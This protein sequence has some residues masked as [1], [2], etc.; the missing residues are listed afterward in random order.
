M[1]KQIKYLLGVLILLLI[2]AYFLSLLSG[3]PQ[4]FKD[5]IIAFLEER[6]SGDISFSSVSLWPLNRL[7]LQSFSFTAQNGSRFIFEELNLDYNLNLSNL[8]KIIE[9]KLIEAEKA[10]IVITEDFSAEKNKNSSSALDLDSAADNQNGFD[11][12]NFKL[13]EFLEGINLNILDTKLKIQNS[14]YNL[15]FDNLNLGLVGRGREEY[16]LNL[17]TA[18]LVNNLSF[19]NL[20]L[21]N[22]E[23]KKIELQ[24]Q[25]QHN[26]AEIYFQT[27]AST[28]KPFL[29]LLPQQNYELQALNLDLNNV[30]GSFKTKGE[31]EIEGSEITNYKAEVNFE[32]LDLKAGYQKQNQQEDFFVNL[33]DLNLA[34]S[35]PDFTLAAVNNQLLLDNNQLQFSLKL[36]HELRYQLELSA[37]DFKYDYQLLSPQIEKGKFDLDLN[38]EGEKEEITRARLEFRGEDIA[39]KYG[40]IKDSYFFVELLDQ[41]IFVEEAEIEMENNS[42]LKLQASYDLNQG[43]YLLSAESRDMVISDKLILLLDEYELPANYGQQFSKLENDSLDFKVDAAGHYSR[44]GGISAAGDFD[45]SFD[46][47]DQDNDFNLKS[48]FWY[49]DQKLFFNSLK[50]SS[51]FVYLDLLGEL[52]FA[53]DEF[54]LSYAA[55]NFEPAVLT[56]NF[57]LN[58]DFPETLNPTIKYAEG[59]ITES[60]NDPKITADLNLNEL[61]YQ[62]YA[63]DS[64]NIKAVYE[65][66]NLKLT[67]ARAALAQALIRVS[68]EINDLSGAA[69]M[70]LNLKS[71][72]LYFEDLSQSFGVELPLDGQ[73]SLKAVLNG[74]VQDYNLDLSLDTS[75]TVFNYNEREIQLSNLSSTI[76]KENDNFIIENLSFEQQDLTFAAA[77][78]YNLDSGFDLNYQLN[79]IELQNY[80]GNYPQVA[81]KT[82][83]TLNLEGQL[84]GQPDGLTLNFNLD[85]EDLSYDSIPLEI[86]ENN[87]ELEL[88]QQRLLV[89][90]FAFSAGSGSYQISG[91]VLDLFTVPRSSLNLKLIEVPIEEYFQKY[92]AFYPFAQQMILKGETELQTEG[93]DY[94]AALNIDAYLAQKEQS[95][96]SLNGE[97][98]REVNLKFEASELPLAFSTE[99]YEINLRTEADLSFSGNIA[100]T[101]LNPTLNL[102]H[103]LSSIE[104]NNTALEAVD[105]DILLESQRR[106]SVSE[107]IS[108]REGGSLEI[109]GSYSFVED[110][111]SLSSNLQELPA[112]FI[113]SFFGDQISGD[114]QLNGNFRAEGSLEKPKLSGSLG[115]S[116]DLLEVGIWAPIE[117]YR[118]E[119]ELREGKALVKELRGDFVDGS[120][121]AGGQLNLFDSDNF[122]DLNLSAE[123]LYFDY[124]S[125]KGDF[126]SSLSFSGPLMKPLL[127]GEL[128]LY[129]FTV[130]IPFEW[131]AGDQE[132]E[133]GLV[134]AV[135]L[136]LIP[137]ENVRVKNPNMDVLIE[138]GDLSIDF[139]QSRDNQLM[140]EGRLRSNEG[141]FNYYNSRFNLNSAEVLF[142]PVDEGDIPT[143]QAAATTYASGREIYI[144]VSG[145][146][147]NMRINLSSDSEMTEDEILN[148]LSSR[149]ALGSAVIGGEDIGIQQ[150]ILQELI[151]I[152]N[153]FLQEDLISDIESDFRTALSLDRIE[154]DAFQYGLEREF[155]LYLGKNLSDRFYLEYASFF[156][157]E[158][159]EQ[160]ISFQ[161]RLNEITNLKGTYFGD[162]EYEITIESEIEF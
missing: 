130:G 40:N 95:S 160:E 47:S 38:L 65:N 29:S 62:N 113:L 111:L 19:N 46:F 112:A 102:S 140:M 22:F 17:S 118:G 110:D 20:K 36:D 8:D 100:G 149:G 105:G 13:P 145:P 89:N 79:N 115:L 139:D 94:T 93:S 56:E 57:N 12:S 76:T 125:L 26:K 41:E 144:N 52:D 97:I 87:F 154:I 53:A 99:Q 159:R 124:G 107:T 84:Q 127:A 90:N 150:I 136:E 114:G 108:F 21:E 120:F 106:F 155:A 25:R 50:F 70:N 133:S 85:A 134:P 119:I 101:L 148:L 117:N 122:W 18:V 162:Q 72:N 49:V 61:S 68:G 59:Q 7:R 51:D 11:I 132:T 33:D 48:E 27:E 77:G 37:A 71:E 161:Y 6:F 92:L 86:K 39:G 147:D 32:S 54:N 81:V 23:N 129:D 104:I 5:D 151:R 121:Q 58:F 3:L 43:N 91:E 28:L 88:G 24:L 143:L 67:D 63:L 60:F 55:R 75:N 103:T 83:G 34:I 141:R 10:E 96:F 82:S 16:Q 156:G 1:D 4:Y 135:D 66:D 146:A 69:Q 157:Q 64:I 138:N 14:S 98:G 123:K 80:L 2:A 153:G 44:E 137:G 42:K 131:P 128:D 9:I 158:E 78:T 73:L 15:E 116:G 142:T 35:G 45:F 126:D 109:D 74:A 152:V 31:V 30:K